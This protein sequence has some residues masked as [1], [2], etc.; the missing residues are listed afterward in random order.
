M[1]RGHRRAVAVLAVV[2]IAACTYPGAALTSLIARL[3][4]AP[5]STRG[6]AGA[7]PWLHVAHPRAGVPY[8]ADEQGRMVLL[9]GAIP[10]GLIDFWGS[11]NPSEAT[12]P[13]FYPIDPAAYDSSCPF[14][15]GWMPTPPL[16]EDDLAQMAQLGFNSVR[17]P[18]SWSLLE[19][20]RGRFDRTYLDR[21]AQV[22]GWARA[23][24]LYVI[25]DMHQNGYG[26]YLQPPDNGKLR[27][28][29]GR[30]PGRRSRTGCLHTS[31]STSAS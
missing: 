10:Q 31:I 3:S 14:N 29:T 24:G 2:V 7:L 20:E 6:P 21:V 18:L 15:S 23:Q 11:G 8:I 19:P 28:Y 22:V 25:I 12:P 1:K 4:P 13:P 5:A 16:C 17:L 27:Y 9:H 26:R 30:R